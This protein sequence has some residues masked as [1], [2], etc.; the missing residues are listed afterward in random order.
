MKI[1]IGAWV[2]NQEFHF[3]DFNQLLNENS[4][5]LKTPFCLLI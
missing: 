5:P 1:E 3:A 2:K 4:V